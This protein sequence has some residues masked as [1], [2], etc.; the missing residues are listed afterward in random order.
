MKINSL[1]NEG[2]ESLKDISDVP[3]REAEYILMDLLNLKKIDLIIDHDKEIDEQIIE[4]FNRKIEERKSGKPLSY[5]LGSEEFMG[6][7]FNVN[8][9]VLIPRDDTEI[10]V[11]KIIELNQE[12]KDLKILD[13]GTG[14]GAI[15]IALAKYLDVTKVVAVDKYNEALTVAKENAKINEVSDQI[16]FI[17]SDLFEKLIRYKHTFDIIVSN[18][19]YIPKKDIPALQVEI[20]AHEPIT[21]LDGGDD[22]LDFYRRII[23]SSK[24]F[25]KANGLLAF[26]IGYDQAKDVCQLMQKEFKEIEVIKDLSGLDRVVLGFIN[27]MR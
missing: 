24:H 11:E 19:P 9:N 26:E 7:T 10:L 15:A 27:K 23:Q 22:G 13:L 21:A 14:S 2:E 4:L 1:I 18:P 20:K 8:E 3:R 25:L 17:Q 6:L 12:K 5:I 16:E